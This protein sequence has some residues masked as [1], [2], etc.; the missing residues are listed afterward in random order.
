MFD[1][2]YSYFVASRQPDC[3]IHVPNPNVQYTEP[4]FF[5][6]RRNA[7]EIVVANILNKF[8]FRLTGD[9]P[10]TEVGGSLQLQAQELSSG[11]CASQSRRHQGT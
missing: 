11:N 6:T 3:H 1:Y 9:P 2:S 4:V 10:Q 5:C 7:P 8:Q